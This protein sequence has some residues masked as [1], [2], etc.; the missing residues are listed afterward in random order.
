MYTIEYYTAVRKKKI[1]TFAITRMNLE[2]V[3]ISELSQTERQMLHDTPYM[4]IRKKLNS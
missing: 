3:M 1:P 4:W 2:E